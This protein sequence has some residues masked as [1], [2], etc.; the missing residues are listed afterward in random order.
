M[1]EPLVDTYGWNSIQFAVRLRVI[2]RQ[3]NL[4]QDELAYRAGVS[5]N[6]VSN[7]ESYGDA[8]LS[9]I[10]AISNAMR[11]PLHAWFLPD[12]EWRKWYGFNIPKEE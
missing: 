2:R 3:C 9:T 5:R 4:S 10:V 7:M 12:D 6:T 8:K 1:S 11:M